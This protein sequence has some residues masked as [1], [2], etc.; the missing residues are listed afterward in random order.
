MALKSVSF[1]VGTGECNGRCKHCAGVQ[2]R[3]YAPKTDG[4]IDSDLI[5]STL[6]DCYERGAR[7]LSISS[8]GEP[9]LS[10]L[11]VTKGLEIVK[12]CSDEDMHYSPVN[13]YSNGIRIGEEVDFASEYLPLWKTLG[14][15]KIYVTVHNVDEVKNAQAYGIDSY[16]LLSLIA[17]RVH[18]AGLELRGNIVLSKDTIGT[19]EKF[20]SNV[21]RMLE[22]GFDS[23]S[24]WPIRTIDDVVDTESSPCEDE[25]LKMREWASRNNKVRLLLEDSKIVYDDG[26][27]LTLFPN[28][29]LSNSWC[30]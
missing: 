19:Y 11:S 30:N 3:R 23:V 8:S 9:T 14:L 21:S 17:E 24:T 6:V 26:E 27:K 12:R 7:S 2:L 25:L 13:L 4:E 29:V 1:F 16:P 10:P 22:V 20:V 5:Y 18:G 28:G 15:S